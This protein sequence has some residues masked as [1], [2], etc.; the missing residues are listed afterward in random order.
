VLS[1]TVILN[2]PTTTERDRSVVEYLER[3]L[4]VDAV[5]LGREM[6]EATSD[7]SEVSAAEIIARDAKHYQVRGGQT[8]CI[9]QVEVVGDALRDRH[10][11]LLD[12][13]R[14]DRESKG[15]HLYALMVTDVLSKSSSLLVAGDTMGAAR[16]FGLEAQDGELQLPGV[17][18][19]KKQVAPRLL[20]TL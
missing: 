4:A 13:L 3:V 16:A 1:D 18:S 19:R 9:A 8:I 20:A 17:M 14:K 2:S 15:L 10:G 5:A 11:E 6:F 7:V 12:A